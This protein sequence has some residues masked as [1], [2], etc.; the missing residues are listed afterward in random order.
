[1]ATA[2]AAVIIF[3][4]LFGLLGVLLLALGLRGRRI[5]DHPICRGCAFDLVGV[6]PGAARCPEC[7]NQLGSQRSV[8]SGARRRRRG[9]LI[10]AAPLL[11]VGLAGGGFAGWAAATNY[12]WYSAC[13]DWLLESLADSANPAR[14]GPAVGE[15]AIRLSAGELDEGRAARL[16]GRGLAI[17][18]D[19][20]RPWRTEWGDLID[21]AAAASMLSP[22]QIESYLAHACVFS[23]E[24]RRR[25]VAGDQ[26]TVQGWIEPRRVGS[27]TDLAFAYAV[28]GLKI[29]DQRLPDVGGRSRA[30]MRGNNGRAGTSRQYT[31]EAPPGEYVLSAEFDVQIGLGGPAGLTTSLAPEEIGAAFTRRVSCPVEVVAP[32]TR[33]VELVDAPELLPTLIDGIRAEGFRVSPGGGD[34]ILD[35]TVYGRKLPIDCVFEVWARSGGREQRWGVAVFPRGADYGVSSSS[36]VEGPIGETIDLVLRATEEAAQRHSD[37]TS[38]WGGEIV[39]EGVPVLRADAPS[40][41]VPITEEEDRAESADGG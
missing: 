5:D 28:Q 21:A 29:G 41:I 6:Y 9:M 23:L 34:L 33:L 35:G 15:L 4:A 3:L 8:R 30:Y 13:P 32:G 39:I 20:D 11:A 18:A 22:E 26:V 31:F 7:G 38:V 1:M 17:Q 24:T 37:L 16:V 10:A 27:A 14:Q 19:A 40:G 2:P 12:N 36:P 25:A